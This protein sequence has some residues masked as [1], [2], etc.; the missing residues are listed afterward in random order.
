MV[1]MDAHKILELAR[2]FPF[3]YT[4]TLITLVMIFEPSKE[5]ALIAYE[6]VFSFSCGIFLFIYFVGSFGYF[7]KY[8]QDMS[9]K[10][11]SYGI[12]AFVLG[13]FNSKFISKFKA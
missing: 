4:L 11:G 5:R 2:E 13:L 8:I 9:A 10:V 7:D 3:L 6:V 1:S 12:S